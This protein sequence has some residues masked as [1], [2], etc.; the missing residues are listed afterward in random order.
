LG[1][2]LNTNASNPN[3]NVCPFLILDSFEKTHPTD[4]GDINDLIFFNFQE[5]NLISVELFSLVA[6]G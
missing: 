5:I 4:F 2:Y 3:F 1:N 6:P